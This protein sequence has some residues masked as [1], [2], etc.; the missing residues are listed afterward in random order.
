MSEREYK[1]LGLVRMTIAVGALLLLGSVLLQIWAVR[2]QPQQQAGWNYLAGG[3]KEH[4]VWSPLEVEK[5]L[6][7]NNGYDIIWMD[8]PIVEKL[9]NLLG[10]YSI[11][12]EL[13]ALR[14][15]GLLTILPLVL[16]S[17]LFGFCEGRIIYHEKIASF[18]N[19]SA[20]RF[21]VFT[22]LAVFCFALTFIFLTLPFGAE[23]PFVGTIPL[24]LNLGGYSVWVTAPYVWAGLFALFIFTV[25]QQITGN[26]ARE[27]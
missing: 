24:T 5:N 21:R 27:V 4:V 25:A 2:Q 22:F 7:R 3:N 13:F 19:L 1:P 17:F 15:Y 10:P 18:G 14:F 11:I 23:L 16:F 26:F 8:G 9:R 12:F 6:Y 20:V